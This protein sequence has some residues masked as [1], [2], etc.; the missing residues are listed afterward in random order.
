M[1]KVILLKFCGYQIIAGSDF[2]IEE[3][4]IKDQ[5]DAGIDPLFNAMIR[6]DNARI[7]VQHQGQSESAK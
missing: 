7:R 4:F 1:P 5:I 2:P 6:V 3:A